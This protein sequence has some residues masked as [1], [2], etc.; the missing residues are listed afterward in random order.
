MTL[1]ELLDTIA[2]K[3]NRRALDLPI[4]VVDNDG[5]QLCVR[6]AYTLHSGR[7]VLDATFLVEAQRNTRDELDADEIA[8]LAQQR[9]ENGKT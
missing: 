5:L 7:I 8:D 6:N 3:T 1:N 4:V 2:G 9:K